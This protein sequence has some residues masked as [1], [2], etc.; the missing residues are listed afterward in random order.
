MTAHEGELI[1]VTGEYGILLGLLK[2]T[3][4]LFL[5]LMHDAQLYN[6][7]S[8]SLRGADTGKDT[9]LKNFICDTQKNKDMNLIKMVAQVFT[10]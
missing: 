5:K 2:H 4:W 6:K 3:A 10:C 9:T 1:G 8:Q 7:K